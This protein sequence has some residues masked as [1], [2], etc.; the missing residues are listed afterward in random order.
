MIW[1]LAGAL[2]IIVILATKIYLLKKSA[3]EIKEQVSDKLMQDTNTSICISSVDRD[4]RSLASELNDKLD[5]LRAEYI[6]YN[7][8]DAELKTAV[9]NISHDLRTPIAAIYGY[10]DFLKKEEKSQKAEEYLEIIAGRTEAL[11]QLTEEL[12]KYSSAISS[13]QQLNLEDMAINGILE[14]SILSYYAVMQENGITPT[15]NITEKRV[16]CKVDKKALSRVYANLISNALKYSS[17][18]FAIT[19]KDDGTTEFSN[20]TDSLDKLQVEKLFDRFYTVENG[21][22]SSGLGLSIAKVFI[23]QMNGT[24]SADYIDGILKITIK[25]NK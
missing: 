5:I 1:C 19:L 12:L 11:K 7:Q 14:E 15:I 9:T 6:R 25:F 16:I 13:K 10:L 21:K 3:R 2:I 23:E 24:I 18:D 8:G 4:M 22:R 17:G 20:R